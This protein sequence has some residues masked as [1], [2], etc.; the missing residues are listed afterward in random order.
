VVGGEVVPGRMPRE[1]LRRLLDLDLPVNLIHGNGDLAV[2]AQIAARETG[3]VTYSGTTSGDPL[4]EP[5]HE[6]MRWTARQL[7]PE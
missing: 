5:L 1:T 3:E 2:V 6:V 4:P 7:H